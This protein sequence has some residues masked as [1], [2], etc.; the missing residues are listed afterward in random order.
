[1]TLAALNLQTGIV[2]RFVRYVG[3]GVLCAIIANAFLI[4]LV[5]SGFSYTA[6]VLI[7]CGPMLVI[8]Y[9]LHAIVTFRQERSLAGFLRYGGA[10][11]AG[12]PLSLACLFVL[13]DLLY[14]PI[15]IAGPLT[16]GFSFL[17]NYVS[18]HWAIARSFS[19]RSLW[20]RSQPM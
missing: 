2:A 16:T 10:V 12:I 7:A 17:C 9:C 13:C 4:G 8:G 1:M 5:W 20:R 19:A 6:G 3:V 18:A 11:I 14:A 15:W